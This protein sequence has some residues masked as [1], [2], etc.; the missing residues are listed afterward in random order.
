MSDSRE[1]VAFGPESE[2]LA[3]PDRVIAAVAGAVERDPDDRLTD[4]SVFGQQ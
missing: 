1:T 3:A 2:D 4:A